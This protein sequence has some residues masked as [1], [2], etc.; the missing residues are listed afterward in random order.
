MEIEEIIDRIEF[1][2]GPFPRR[3]LKKAIEKQKEITPHLLEIMRVAADDV[4]G[5]A[6]DMAYIGHISAMFLLAQFRERQA[7]PAIVNFFLTPGEI[8]LDATDDIVTEDL[9][10]ILAS[11]CGDDDSLIRAMIENE[12]A[13]EFVRSAAM[14]ALVVL[15]AAGVKSREE[16]IDYFKGLFKHDR[17]SYTEFLW[18]ALTVACTDLYPEE[19]IDEIREGMVDGRIDQQ[20]ID[21][22]FVDQQMEIGKEKILTRLNGDHYSLI[23]D[24]VA[25]LEIVIPADSRP[26]AR[27]ATGKR[28]IGRNEP[29]PCGSGKKYKKCCGA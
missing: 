10:R 28:K 4:V 17:S 21:M 19:V 5:T 15:V 12:K 22:E 25:E 1:L 14:S 18:G 26:P 9:H 23:D 6:E 2:E 24:A 20:F 11:V 7:Y 29:C 3:A 27:Q 8:A 16:I 13:N